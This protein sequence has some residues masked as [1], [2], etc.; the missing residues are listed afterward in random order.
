LNFEYLCV[1][2]DLLVGV[3]QLATLTIKTGSLSIP[4]PTDAT[5]TSTHPLTITPAGEERRDEGEGRE[6]E[7]GVCVVKVPAQGAHSVVEVEVSVCLPLQPA[8]PLSLSTEV[9]CLLLI[10]LKSSFI[11]T[12]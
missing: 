11:H 5:L 10:M 3:T 8:S 4:S 2:G 9:S 7:G 6:G 12:F 1:S